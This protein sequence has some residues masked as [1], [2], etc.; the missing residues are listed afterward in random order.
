LLGAQVFPLTILSR[1]A[2]F[3]SMT[4]AEARSRGKASLLVLVVLFSL[5]FGCAIFF[6]LQAYQVSA[7][8]RD[9]ASKLAGAELQIEP[10]AE[11]DPAR[12]L[13]VQAVLTVGQSPDN[14]VHVLHL[15]NVGIRTLTLG[16]MINQR[17]LGGGL[18]PIYEVPPGTAAA[19]SLP[20]LA[21]GDQIE[22]EGGRDFDPLR[23]KVQ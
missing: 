15:V 12:R 23:L 14:P 21:K 8:L 5:M 17:E 2:I 19:Y 10:A 22:I 16:I 18:G 9:T 3:S 4:E 11:A 1:G 6:A 13:P 7:E 20:R